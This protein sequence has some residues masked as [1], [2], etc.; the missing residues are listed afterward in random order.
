MNAPPPSGSVLDEPT[1]TRGTTESDDVD[2]TRSFEIPDTILGD[3]PPLDGPPLPIDSPDHPD[4][5]LITILSWA[6]V[7]ACCAVVFIAMQPK[8]LLTNSTPTGGDMGAHVWGPNYLAKHLLPQFRLSGWTPDWYAGFP[9]YTFYMVVP[10]LL[11]VVLAAGPPLW[12]APFLLAAVAA[13]AWALNKRITSPVLRTLMFS[14]AGVLAVLCLPVPYNVAFKLVTVAGLVTMPLALFALGRAAR[15]PFPGPP[16]LAMAGLVFLFD[17]SYTIL[18]GNIASTMAGEF[19]FSLSLTLSVVYLAVLVRGTRTGGDRALGAFLFALVALCHLIPAIFAGLATVIIVL[20]RREDRVP[21]WDASRIGRLVAA[22]AVFVVIG[23]LWV[24]PNWFPLAGTAAALLLFAGFDV[25]SLKWASVALP[26]GGLVAAFWIVPFY[27]NSPYLND[28]GWEKYTDYKKY[29]WPDPS[30]AN[31]PYRNVVFALAGLGIVLS[32]VHRVRLGWY[33]TLLVVMLAWTFR[34]LPQ[35]R[36]WN[37]RL[38]P[39]YYFSLYVLAGLAVALVLRSLA[40]VVQDL[41]RRRD[42][43]VLVGA[44]G[45][46]VVL[47]VVVVALLGPLRFLPGGSLGADPAK[48]GAQMYSWAGLKFRNTNFVSD[49][50]RWNYSGLEGKEA[51]PEYKGIMDTM[52]KVGA[53][54]GCGRALW[55]YESDLNRFGTPMALMLLPYFTDSCIGSMEGLYFEASSTTPF[56]FLMQ[57]ELSK[58][59]SRAQRDMPYGELDIA[60][61]VSHLQLLGVKYYMAFSDTAIAGASAEPR[62]KEVASTGKWKVYEVAGTEQV[63]PLSYDPVVL[64]NTDGHIDGWVYD[65]IR[66]EPVE[67][68]IVAP[69]TPGPAVDWF[70]DSTRSQIP[71]AISGPES[72]PRINP[73]STDLPRQPVT[74]AKVSKIKTTDNSISFTVDRVGSP[75]L[76]KTSYFP[77]WEVSGATGPYRVSP[78][79]MVVVPT[80]KNVTL[81]YGRTWIDYLG[82]LLTLVGAVL[83][84]LLAKSDQRRKDAESELVVDDDPAVDGGP[85]TDGAPVVDGEPV[86]DGDPVAD[87]ESAAVDDEE[88]APVE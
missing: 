17:N 62:L 45:G 19:A 82:W 15:L 63:A 79:Q 30:V 13:G 24:A 25:R 11:I 31:M 50:A 51:W 80:E 22:G 10:S 77:N 14:V 53:T 67:G 36:L 57:S 64:R 6:A 29:L 21:W 42:E 56:H 69:K 9:A 38:L 83:L 60:K 16:L 40:V 4:R 8:L 27:L 26:V 84:G 65:K 59:P 70:I 76:V 2:R 3:E 87:G 85:G 49:W 74:P 86:A 33:F 39:F 73:D 81:N 43:P 1:V 88:T 55:E 52:T 23:T 5:R 18:G 35:Y 32:I 7:A 28:M 41:S 54:N 61:G 20:T 68:Q 48:P 46:G 66:P 72:W 44:I 75:V 37:A 58:A 71:L 34:Y 47:A 78:N 12:L